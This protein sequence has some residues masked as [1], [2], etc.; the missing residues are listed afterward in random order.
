MRNCGQALLPEVCLQDWAVKSRSR[1]RPV[2][3]AIFYP[4]PTLAGVGGQIEFPLAAR[5]GND[6]L[7]GLVAKPRYQRHACRIRRL[8]FDWLKASEKEAREQTD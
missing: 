7:C 8:S 1:S 6:F 3:E 2:S 4:T 5:S